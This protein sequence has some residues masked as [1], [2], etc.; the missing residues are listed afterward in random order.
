MQDSEHYPR[1]AVLC[2]GYMLDRDGA[3]SVADA[4]KQWGFANPTAGKLVADLRRDVPLLLARAGRD[5][6]PGLNETLDRCVIQMLS[7][8]LPVTLVNYS[9]GPHA[10]DIVDDTPMSREVIRWIL[11]FLQFHLLT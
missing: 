6:M 1:C 3:T 8:N 9:V 2:Y 11:A 10:F 7:D 4:A 5:Q